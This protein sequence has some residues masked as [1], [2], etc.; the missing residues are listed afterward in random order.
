MQGVELG[1]HQL[2]VRE[3]FGEAEQSA[4]EALRQAL[5]GTRAFGEQDQ[6]RAGVEC[7][8]DRFERIA[9]ALFAPAFD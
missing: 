3:G 4:A 2:Q 9:V 7:F 6:R 1:G 5:G 8:V